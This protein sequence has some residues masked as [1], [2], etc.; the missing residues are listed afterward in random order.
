VTIS[1]SRPEDVASFRS[2]ISGEKRQEK[3]KQAKRK[4]DGFSLNIYA[5]YSLHSRSASSIFKQRMERGGRR[6]MK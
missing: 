2:S 1:P 4:I 6:G 3:I 5:R